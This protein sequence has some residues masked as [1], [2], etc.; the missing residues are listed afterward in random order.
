MFD[1]LPH[2]SLH[3]LTVQCVNTGQPTDSNTR[4]VYG[5]KYSKFNINPICQ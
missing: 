2:V 1:D 3:K 5:L 4:V